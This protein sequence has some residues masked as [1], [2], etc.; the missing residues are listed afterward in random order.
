MP[1]VRILESITADIISTATRPTESRAIDVVACGHN[2]V[3][4]FGSKTETNLFQYL[5]RG[6]QTHK[7]NHV[8]INISSNTTTA[9]TTTGAP[10]PFGLLG[11]V[12]FVAVPRSVIGNDNEPPQFAFPSRNDKY[13]LRFSAFQDTVLQG[14]A[15]THR[16]LFGQDAGSA[17]LFDAGRARRR[18][19][20]ASPFGAGRAR[21]GADQKARCRSR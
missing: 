15:R 8:I 3:F 10:A 11:V 6:T 12:A 17:S 16:R 9:T 2:L 1:S 19:G 7:H 14:R 21:R 4:L 13:T 20:R 18:P 5:Q